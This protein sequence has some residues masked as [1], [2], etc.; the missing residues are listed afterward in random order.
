MLNNNSMRIMTFTII[1][2]LVAIVAYAQDNNNLAYWTDSAN[3]KI[4]NLEIEKGQSILVRLKAEIPQ[5][6]ILKAYSVII[7]FDNSKI[8]VEANATPNSR[9]VPSNVSIEDSGAIIINGFDVKGITGKSTASITDI[10]ITGKETGDFPCSILFT[11]FG[12]KSD[13]QFLPKGDYLTILV[14]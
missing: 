1:I 7:Y 6:K 13:D 10:T 3:K 9:I 8:S 12:E 11:A 4:N 5:N 2:V 14:K